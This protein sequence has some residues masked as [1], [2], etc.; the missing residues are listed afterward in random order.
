MEWDST[1]ANDY[2]VVAQSRWR[3]INNYRGLQ[4]R[5]GVYVFANINLQVK[6]VGKAGP[7]RIVDEITN[8]LYRRKDF[9]AT[10]VKALYTNSDSNAL[11]LE[12]KLID[13]YDPPNNLI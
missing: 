4:A 10:R 11:S 7:G 1:D 8:A 12:R 6:Y 2:R 3:D 13:L 5:A 9:G